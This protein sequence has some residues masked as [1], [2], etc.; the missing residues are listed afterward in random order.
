[1]PWGFFCVVPFACTPRPHTAHRMSDR[2][3][4]TPCPPGTHTPT[5][6]SLPSHGAIPLPPHGLSSPS[7]PDPSSSVWPCTWQT[8]PNGYGGHV[9]DRTQLRKR[10]DVTGC[11]RM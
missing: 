3:R 8:E 2:A 1:L 4:S 5:P 9:V 7:P 6:R 11:D 10:Q